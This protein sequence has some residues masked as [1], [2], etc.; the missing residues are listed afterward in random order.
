[1]TTNSQ[2]LTY[3]WNDTP[4]PEQIVVNW[5]KIL[6][7]IAKILDVPTSLIMRVHPPTIEVFVSSQTKNNPYHPHE[8]AELPGLY[9]NT[10]MNQKKSLLIPNALKNPDWANNPDVELGM[11]SYL[12]YPLL[13]PNGDMFG[14]ICVLDSK[15]NAYNQDQIELLNQFRQ[16]VENHLDLIETHEK[17]NKSQTELK[18]LHEIVPK[19][20]YCNK[21]RIKEE[22]YSVDEYLKNQ[23][24]THVSHT[25]C[26]DCIEQH[27]PE[28]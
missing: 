22:W 18:A 23:K 2:K 27:F 9:C 12:G 25:I 10:V 20:A 5:Q 24:K 13:W 14:T 28:D 26:P 17:L 6:N 3:N 19:C 1:M 7:I 8:I 11:I 21:F 16:M 15:E 4:I